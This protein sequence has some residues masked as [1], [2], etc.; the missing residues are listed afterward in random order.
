V[1]QGLEYSCEALDHTLAD[2]GAAQLQPQERLI[3]GGRGG[4]RSPAGHQPERFELA[5]HQV[6]DVVRAHLP[7]EG[8][9]GSLGDLTDRADAVDP[10]QHQVQQP[11]HLDG[12]AT[13]LQHQIGRLGQSR[14][15]VLPGEFHSGEQLRHVVRHGQARPRVPSSPLRR[16]G[17]RRRCCDYSRGS[18]ASLIRGG[19]TVTR[20]S[21]GGA[22]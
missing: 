19:V 22:E 9:T 2:H 11:G 3:L 17:L 7:A 21:D 8:G 13:R 14:A 6:T 12:L 5:R 15:L 20:R 18:R 10:F 1:E 16:S 4:V